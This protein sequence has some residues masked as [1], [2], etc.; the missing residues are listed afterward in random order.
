ML[1]DSLP[2][3]VPEPFKHL[4]ASVQLQ[5][6]RYYFEINQE[7]SKNKHENT[8]RQFQ[9]LYLLLFAAQHPTGDNAS[10]NSMQ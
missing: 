10:C 2:E 4:L 3:T 1:M 5:Q 8:A 7:P 6:W 9:S